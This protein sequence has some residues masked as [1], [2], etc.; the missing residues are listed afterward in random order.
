MYDICTWW[1]QAEAS[2]GGAREEKFME[3]VTSIEGVHEY[4]NPHLNVHASTRLSG[5]FLFWVQHAIIIII[6]IVVTV[7][8]IIIA[9]QLGVLSK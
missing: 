4:I 9:H 3:D 5:L 7:I 1:L 8:I 6:I 2:K